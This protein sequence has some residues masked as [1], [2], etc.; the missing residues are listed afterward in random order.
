MSNDVVIS[1]R[2]RL[3]RNL[4]DFPF[5]CK[6]NSQGREKVIEKVRDAVKKSN[7]PVASDFSFIKMSELTSSQSVSL[8]EKRLVSPEFISDTDGRA[9]LISKDECFSI[10]INEED[11]I[12]LQVITKGLSLEQAYD[13]AD[14]LDTLLDENLDFAFDEKLGYLTQCPTN[15]GTGM[16]ASVMLHLPALEKSRAINRIAG[17]L[18]K[19]GLTIRGAHGEGTEPKGALYQ[20]SNQVTLGIS[21]KAAI[22]NLKNI[23]EQLI[24]Q[25]NQARERLCS[26][27][28]IQD[29][30]SR[31][32]G[33]LRS[34][35][36]I[37]HDE[38][39]KLL[40]NVRLGIVS[41]QITDVSTETIDRLMLA[42]EPATLT[43]ALNK[44]LSAHDRDIERAKLI[45]A[46]L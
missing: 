16:R 42:V 5:P 32:L 27:I 34:A 11:H 6:L 30:I 9:L 1:T 31:S 19:L 40:S 3:A 29:A 36:V 17:N 44:N 8:V 38:A 14:K 15:L 20:L 43:V 33:I 7:S 2:I 22:E 45:R 18:S 21:E 23:T 10:M 28:D 13:T 24:A 4:K 46:E 25:E 37:S 12:R 35:L 39:L 26:S 41:K